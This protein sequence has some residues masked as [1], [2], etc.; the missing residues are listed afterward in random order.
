LAMNSTHHTRPVRKI[1][2]TMRRSRMRT[3]R[4]YP[5]KLGRYLSAF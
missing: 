1:R 2:P 3:G 5:G 4:T